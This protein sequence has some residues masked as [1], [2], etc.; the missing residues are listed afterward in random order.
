MLLPGGSAEQARPVLERLEAAISANV[1][2][3]DGA[4]IRITFGWAAAGPE[5]DLRTLTEQADGML[6]ARKVARA[7]AGSR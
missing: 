3:P 7:G 1:S 5:T 6:L 4:P 2:D